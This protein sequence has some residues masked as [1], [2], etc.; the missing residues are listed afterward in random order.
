MLNYKFFGFIKIM[1]FINLLNIFYNSIDC[2]F[3]IKFI[4]KHTKL[5]I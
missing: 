1:K 5:Y 4:N 2:T 3:N